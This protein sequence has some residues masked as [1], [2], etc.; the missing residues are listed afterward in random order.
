MFTEQVA[1]SRICLRKIVSLRYFNLFKKYRVELI[2]C[3]FFEYQT[4]ELDV[5]KFKAGLEIKAANTSVILDLVL[6][7]LVF[8]AVLR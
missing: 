3:P 8:Q 7:A 4:F 2:F 6:R 5:T 1:W